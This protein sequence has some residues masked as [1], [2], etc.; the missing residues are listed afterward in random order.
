MGAACGAFCDEFEAFAEQYRE[1]EDGCGHLLPILRVGE[2][3]EV[4]SVRPEHTTLGITLC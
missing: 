3:F 1:V 2:S 4:L